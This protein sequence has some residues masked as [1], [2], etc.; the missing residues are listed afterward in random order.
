MSP[1]TGL[2]LYDARFSASLFSER[3]WFSLAEGACCNHEAVDLFSMLEVDESQDVYYLPTV[4]YTLYF[5]NVEFGMHDPQFFN[6]RG[7]G[8][9]ADTQRDT[10][11][12]R[13]MWLVHVCDNFHWQ[14]LCFIN[15]G[16]QASFAILMDS[17]LSSTS[18]RP[19]NF[20]KCC[21]FATA[22]IRQVYEDNNLY[23]TRR[24][25]PINIGLVT[26]QPN[27]YD[28][29]VYSFLSF[30]NAVARFD[31][32]TEELHHSRTGYDF[33]HW[34]SIRNANEC[35]ATMRTTYDNLLCL[36]GVPD[37]SAEQQ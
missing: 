28:C 16:P 32:L 11:R 3:G 7:S 37:T 36:W 6:Q 13:K 10:M 29:G 8:Q 2:P 27:G 31:E 4:A 1:E 22:L 35:R 25:L 17:L 34:Y 21:R 12:A 14:L 19:T 15:R 30:K 26:N 5:R 23:N 24:G 9:H 20:A 33:Q 18:E